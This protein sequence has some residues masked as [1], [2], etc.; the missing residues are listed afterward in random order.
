MNFKDNF[1][2]QAGLYAKFRPTYPAGLYGY[3]NSIVNA[4][5]LVWDCGTGNGQAAR[6]LALFFKN[7][8]ATD[9]SEDQIAQI[10]SAPANIE[11]RV[12]RSEETSVKTASVDLIT[13]A[14]ALHWFD[15]S[16]FYREA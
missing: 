5:D 7:V 11:F 12:E 1:S 3:L 9:P 15:H 8:I 14:T 16:E 4:H 10:I 6:D 13:V 2:K